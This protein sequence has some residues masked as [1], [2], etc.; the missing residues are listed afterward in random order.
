MLFQVCTAQLL[1]V[2]P[3]GLTASGSCPSVIQIC[4][5]VI[6]TEFCLLDA[7]TKPELPAESEGDVAKAALEAGENERHG[8]GS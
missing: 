8:V 5:F 1:I 4:I 6:M 2:L 7:R 3:S